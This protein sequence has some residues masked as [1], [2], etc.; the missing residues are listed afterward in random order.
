MTMM[1]KMQDVLRLT[2]AGRISEAMAI[3]R[4]PGATSTWREPVADAAPQADILDLVPPIASGEPW[5]V[6]PHAPSPKKATCAGSFTW[7]EVANAA[8][9][10][11]YKLYVPAGTA[12]LPRPLVLM[13][14]G[15]TQSPDDFAAGTRM[16]AVADEL[17]VLVAY[18][19]QTA[20]NN[21][22]KCWN[23]FKPNDQRRGAGEPSLLATVVEAVA[24]EV[25]VDRTRV[26]AVGL[27][28][29]G[30]AAAILAR[31]YPDVFAGVGVH[32]GLAC[33][34]ARDLPSALAAMRNGAPERSPAE[35]AV[36]TIT[37]HG[38]ADAT[39]NPANARHVLAGAIAGLDAPAV[40]RGR[41]PGGAAYTREV[42]RDAQGRPRAE[43]WT[44]EGAG[45]AWSGGSPAGTFTD[46]RGPDATR[47]MMRF[48]LDL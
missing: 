37:F 42:W 19:E 17:G 24:G 28:A 40:D 22:S 10:R 35:G 7:H 21:S 18:P 9:R 6:L 30:A 15:C 33:G 43:A 34:A 3:L 11:R 5:S 26:Y 48:F 27:S 12:A 29:G 46:R 38:S 32:S 45:H 44:I 36:P 23:W 13:L 20:A 41:A 31:E 1:P 39:V 25:P 16:N 2:K 47:A 4:G 8:G 14:H